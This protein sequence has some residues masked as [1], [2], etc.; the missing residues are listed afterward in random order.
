[1]YN[2]IQVRLSS[3]HPRNNEQCYSKLAMGEEII[4]KRS[5]FGRKRLSDITNYDPQRKSSSRF[6]QT[7][8]LNSSSSLA[9]EQIDHLL[10]ENAGLMK[11]INEKNKVIEM[12]VIELQKIRLVLQ[13]TKLQNLNLARSNSHKMAEV[14]LGKKKLKELQHQ[15]S[16]KDA[17]LSFQTKREMDKRNCESKLSKDGDGENT[18]TDQQNASRRIR[19][20]RSRSFSQLN[21][22]EVSANEIVENKRRCLRRQSATFTSEEH[23][24]DEDLFEIKMH[25]DCGATSKVSIE[26]EHDKCGSKPEPQNSQRM[27]LGRPSRRA[28]EKVQS[29]KEV[30]LNMKMRRPE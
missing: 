8:Q 19:P 18:L 14:S 2:A 6:D 16:C 10:K 22:V 1:M 7:L 27:S 20:G 24:P 23:K 30:P 29:Y 3:F 5:S 25:E 15:L 11:L 28:A 21:T 4:A 13:K 17:L 26:Q 9:K 12:N